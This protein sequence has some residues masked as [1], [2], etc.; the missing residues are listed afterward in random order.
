M[1]INQQSLKQ[2]I[3]TRSL[4]LIKAFSWYF[5]HNIAVIGFLFTDNILLCLTKHF[6]IVG[7]VGFFCLFVCFCFVFS[8]S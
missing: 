5:N 1:M 7:L 3:S 4:M 8:D 6:R 2:E